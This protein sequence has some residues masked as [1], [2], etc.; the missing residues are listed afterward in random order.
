MEATFTMTGCTELDET[1]IH[2]LWRET[3][4]LLEPHIDR[5]AVP[6]TPVIVAVTHADRPPSWRAQA[7]VHVPPHVFVAESASDGL[8]DSL[9]VL[10]GKL[11][12]K[13]DGWEDAPLS[14]TRRRTGLEAVE[15]L[16]AKCCAAGDTGAFIQLLAPLVWTL[17]PYVRRELQLAE[18]EQRVAP[19]QLE[20]SEIL[21][22]VLVRASTSFAD[23]PTMPLDLWL[24]RLADEVLEAAAASP[25]WQSLDRRVARPSSEPRSAQ[26]DEWIER[27]DDPD[28]TRM[29]ELL[30]GP[31]ST[32]AWDALDV[33]QKRVALA[34]LLQPIERQDRQALVLHVV[35]G[36]PTTE[37]A[38]FQQRP[39]EEVERDIAL[40]KEQVRRTPAETD[41]RRQESRLEQSRRRGT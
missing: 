21:D 8:R 33:Q 10:A 18:L 34:R 25:D 31:D 38:D 27:V 41:L 22:E 14:V 16:L 4:S 28:T 15:P 7:A 24:I 12:E 32:A 17:Y 23:R 9:V 26:R 13:V 20:A 6:A 37:V 39:L 19:A 11:T 2:N 1:R 36:F 3:Q 29:A 30:P 35:E 40:A 5:L